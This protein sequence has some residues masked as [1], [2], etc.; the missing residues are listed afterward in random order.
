MLFDRQ[1]QDIQCA[2]HGGP[3]III[4]ERQECRP[5]EAVARYIVQM[6]GSMNSA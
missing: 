4:G 3:G 1:L 5:L 2:K 6:I